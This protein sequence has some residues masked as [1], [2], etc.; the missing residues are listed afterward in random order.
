MKWRKL[1]QAIC[2]WW[3]GKEEME[4][5]FTV[6]GKRKLCEDCKHNEWRDAR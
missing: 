5:L 4:C 6:L 2:W 1:I 3:G